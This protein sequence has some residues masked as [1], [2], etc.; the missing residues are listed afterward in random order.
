MR[1]GP[2]RDQEAGARPGQADHE[3][4]LPAVSGLGPGDGGHQGGVT[5]AHHG[6]PGVEAAQVTQAG[7]EAGAEDEGD[8]EAVRGHPGPGVPLHQ[9]L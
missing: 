5:Q 3:A 9:G 7:M 1:P 4:A 8:M 6:Q 2:A